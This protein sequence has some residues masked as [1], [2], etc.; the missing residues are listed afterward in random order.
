MP[1]RE[2]SADWP[3]IEAVA[4]HIG[5]PILRLRFL[6]AVAPAAG[7]DNGTRR[8]RLWTAALVILAIGL[9]L[10][11]FVVSRPKAKAAINTTHLASA[12]IP[13]I[14]AV[15]FKPAGGADVWLVETNGELETYSNGLR[16]DTRF[17]TVTHHRSYL[18]FAVK[19]GRAVAREDPAGIVFHTTES[20]QAP[21]AASE[22]GILKRLGESLL[23]YVRRKQAYHFLIDRFGRTY[24]VVVETDAANHSGYS[25]WADENWSYINLNESFLGIAFEA[26]SP[27]SNGTVEINPAQIRS[28]AMLVELLR[29]RYRM[30]ASNC[31]THAQVSVNPSNMLVGMHRDWAAGFPFEA[32][33]LPDN[34]T[35]PLPALWAYG[36]DC[37]ANFTESVGAPMQ[38][39]IEAGR[40]VLARKAAEARLNLVKYRNHLRQQYRRMRDQVR[41]ARPEQAEAG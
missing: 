19:G 3:W 34:Y 4:G 10:L 33:G 38:V 6:K 22:N 32:V 15:P 7:L 30:P 31:V 40:T 16:I 9:S 28:A 1:R 8:L 2:P 21:F 12:G 17:A 18:A 41:H 36:F 25:A 11:A 39:G 37:D 14:P 29:G 26:V 27:K 13:S 20:P 24:R 23:E 35:V 5:D